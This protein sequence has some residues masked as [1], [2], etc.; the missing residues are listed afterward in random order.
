M[1]IVVNKYWRVYL[2]FGR[3]GIVVY[4]IFSCMT[5]TSDMT[6]S[7]IVFLYINHTFG[8]TGRGPMV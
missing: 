5:N 6:A 2:D 3:A 7:C 8:G 4:R 1:R